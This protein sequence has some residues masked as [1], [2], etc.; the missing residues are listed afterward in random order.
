MISIIRIAGMVNRTEKIENTLDRLRLRR[1]YACVV[2]NESKLLEGMLQKIRNFVAYGNIDREIFL[3]LI[4][5]RGNLID[6]K[7]KTDKKGV[8]EQYFDGKIKKLNEANIKP[9]FRM[10]PPRGGINSKK[11]FPK[12]VLGNNGEKINEL[13]K[14]ML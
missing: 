7:K 1:K 9:F 6:K 5:K 14:R 4:E 10:H 2:L 8:G 3:E 11:H 13:I 12:G